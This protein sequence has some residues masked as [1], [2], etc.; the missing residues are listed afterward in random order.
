MEQK[1][2][3]KYF[4][5]ALAVLLVA[6]AVGG[7]IAWL[8]SQSGLTNSFTVGDVNNPTT[9]PGDPGQPIDPEHPD[10]PQDE[11]LD[12]NLYEPNWVDDSKIMPG[13]SIVKDPYVGIGE[14]SESAY[15]FIYVD[16]NTM[17]QAGSEKDDAPYFVLNGNWAAVKDSDST[18]LA[19]SAVENP[20]AYTSGLFMYSTDST[21]PVLL[22]GFADKDNWTV[23]PIFSEVKTPKNAV[24][25]DFAENPTIDVK[26]YVIV[27]NTPAEA[28]TAAIAWYN[29]LIVQP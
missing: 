15:V 5:A 16:N 1:S 25:S 13:N 18:V 29:D 14:G 6:V 27:T 3:K 28:T 23:N 4:I 20:S 12:G 21:N 19:N 7:T 2:K 10:N 17:S 24:A 26:S 8:N 22:E 11:N 9:E